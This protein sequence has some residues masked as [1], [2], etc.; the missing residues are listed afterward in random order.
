[1]PCLILCRIRR[2]TKHCAIITC[3]IDVL[4]HVRCYRVNTETSSSPSNEVPFNKVDCTCVRYFHLA[5]HIKGQALQVRTDSQYY[6]LLLIWI[7]WIMHKTGKDRFHDSSRTL[8]HFLILGSG[9]GGVQ[10]V[11]KKSLLG[12]LA[13]VKNTACTSDIHLVRE[14]KFLFLCCLGRN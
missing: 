10:G 4:N 7:W 9:E 11:C 14:G 2:R 5:T 6:E 12:H 8:K 13:D 1:M 3:L